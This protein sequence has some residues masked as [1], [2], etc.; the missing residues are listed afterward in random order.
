MKNGVLKILLLVLFAAAANAAPREKLFPDD[1][2][3]GNRNAPVVLVEYFAPMCPHC[4]HFA[5]T[6]FP[7]IK[8]A[9]ID[10]GKVL[11]VLR[12]FPLAA[13]D[14][15]VAGMAKCQKPERYYDFLDL[16]FRKQAMWDPDGYDIP[17]VEAALVQLGGMAGMKP[18]DAKRCMHDQ[19]EFDRLNRLADDAA[20]RFDIH[21]VPSIVLDGKV[22]TGGDQASW[23]ELK[24]RIDAL[25]AKAAAPQPPP[26]KP[27][28][29]KHHKKTKHLSSPAEP[30]RPSR[31]ETK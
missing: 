18:E 31:T 13:P 17:D 14:G 15:A 8:K 4:A 1:R 21:S 29:H 19:A 25:L 3:L 26:Q 24:T 12:I 23:P 16:A 28:H 10:T 5:A 9:Y 27:V 11:Y 20:K 7:E 30:K 2:T 6:V 22:L